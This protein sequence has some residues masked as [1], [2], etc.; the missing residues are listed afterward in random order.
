M[1][2]SLHNVR[3][4]TSQECCLPGFYAIFFC[5][6][7]TRFVSCF[8]SHGLISMSVSDT[9]THTRDLDSFHQWLEQMHR[10]PINVASYWSS[11]SSKVYH[12]GSH[13]SMSLRLPFSLS[14]Y[15]SSSLSLPLSFSFSLSLSL[16]LSLSTS[17]YLS[18][19]S[20][21]RLS[22]QRIVEKI[23]NP[24]FDKPLPVSPSHVICCSCDMLC[25]M[26]FM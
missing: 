21:R 6:S 20:T 12:H 1:D 24:V 4:R 18:L 22:M 5:S 13:T 23:T 9:H 15:L 11:P 17:L 14:L 8:M 26:L 7:P 10:S 3:L 2:F 16:S 25:D 19:Y